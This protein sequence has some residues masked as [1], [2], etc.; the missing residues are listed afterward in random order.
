MAAGLHNNV[1]AVRRA[2]EEAGIEFV[3]RNDGDGVIISGCL[4]RTS[5]AMDDLPSE[6]KGAAPSPDTK[7]I[8]VRSATTPR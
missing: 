5:E 6:L 2:L 1:A 4:I 8:S 3:F 7:R